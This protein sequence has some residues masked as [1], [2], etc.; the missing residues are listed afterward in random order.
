[1]ALVLIVHGLDCKASVGKTT[2]AQRQ[3]PCGKERQ[4]VAPANNDEADVSDVVF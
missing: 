2:A 4:R 1:M 3:E